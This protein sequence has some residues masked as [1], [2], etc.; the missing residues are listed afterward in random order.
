V[1]LID[2]SWGPIHEANIQLVKQSYK[3]LILEENTLKKYD[4]QESYNNFKIKL[5]ISLCESGKITCAVGWAGCQMSVD[6]AHRH[7]FHRSPL[8]DIYYQP[9]YPPIAFQ[10]AIATEDRAYRSWLALGASIVPSPALTAHQKA[11][12]DSICSVRVESLLHNSVD[13]DRVPC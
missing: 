4:L 1:L 7:F 5:K 12:N 11:W 3:F 9:I 2:E 10:S 13:S 8:S 6:L